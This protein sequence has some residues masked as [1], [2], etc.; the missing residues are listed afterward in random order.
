ML[1]NKH[2]QQMTHLDA[3]LDRT[4][5]FYLIEAPFNTLANRAD[6]DQAAFVKAT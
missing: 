3:I 5:T 2:H 6:P 1:E 4:L